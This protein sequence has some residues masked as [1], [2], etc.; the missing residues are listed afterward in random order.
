MRKFLLAAILV[1]LVCTTTGAQ[2]LKDFEQAYLKV[3]RKARPS[4]VYIQVIQEFR[5]IR[6]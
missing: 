4:S 5:Q 2:E 3:V 1:G 6:F